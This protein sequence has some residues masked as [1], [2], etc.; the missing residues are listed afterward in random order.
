[1]IIDY[2]ISSINDEDLLV[3]AIADV[4]R[5]SRQEGKS[6]A[7]ITQEVLADDAILSKRERLLLS[8]ILTA[9]WQDLEIA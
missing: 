3:K 1:M 7:D 6:L 4:V 9:A 2:S 5:I 8:E